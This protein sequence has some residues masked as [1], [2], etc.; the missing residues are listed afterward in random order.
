M[1][2]NTLI[3]AISLRNYMVLFTSRDYEK[4]QDFVQTLRRVGPPMGINIGDARMLQCQDDRTDNLFFPFERL[5]SYVTTFMRLQPGDLISTG[6]PTGAGA[7]FNPPRYLS[8]G[9]VVEVEAP[10]IGLLR[11]DIQDE[12]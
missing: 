1:R 12:F 2:G 7:R 10:S 5:I 11:N 9:D 3:S 6:T 8:P 4:A